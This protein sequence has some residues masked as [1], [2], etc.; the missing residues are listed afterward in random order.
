MQYKQCI[1]KFT[2]IP[3][4]ERN[5][6]VHPLQLTAIKKSNELMAH[7]YSYLYGINT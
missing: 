7:S 5:N 3:F 4:N 6:T 1:W 2:D